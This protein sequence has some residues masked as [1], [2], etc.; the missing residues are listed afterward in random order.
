MRGGG[1][2]TEGEL[3]NSYIFSQ[4]HFEAIVTKHFRYLLSIID[5]IVAKSY[6]LQILHHYYVPGSLVGAKA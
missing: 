5:K 1:V 3:T 4:L 6:I 2:L